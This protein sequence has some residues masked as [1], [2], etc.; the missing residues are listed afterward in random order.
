V[1][2]SVDLTDDYIKQHYPLPTKLSERRSV[3]WETT[4]QQYLKRAEQSGVPALDKQRAAAA[5]LSITQTQAAAITQYRDDLAKAMDEY[6]KRVPQ[7]RLEQEEGEKR[8]QEDEAEQEDEVG[9]LPW[10]F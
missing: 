9:Y 1:D 2:P 10:C 7:P 5:G 8:Q 4:V 6:C 3:N